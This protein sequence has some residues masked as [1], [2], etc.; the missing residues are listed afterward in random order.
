MLTCHAPYTCTL[1]ICRQTA[2]ASSQPAA[3]AAP[4]AAAAAAG[5]WSTPPPPAACLRRSYAWTIACAPKF[6]HQ[7]LFLLLLKTFHSLEAA[8]FPI[9]PA[10]LMKETKICSDHACIS[11]HFISMHFLIFSNVTGHLTNYEL[12]PKRLAFMHL[13]LIAETKKHG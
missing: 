10:T 5:H 11:M 3:A 6:I 1:H 9:T 7:T 12:R 8:S 13:H 4:S 2:A